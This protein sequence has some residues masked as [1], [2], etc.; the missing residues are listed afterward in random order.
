[1]VVT[2]TMGRRRDPYPAE[3]IKGRKDGQQFR[4]SSVE[5]REK[6]TEIAG[7]WLPGCKQRVRDRDRYC[8]PGHRDLGPMLDDG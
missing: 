7:V 6:K 2:Q 4:D 3:G 1:M 5:A 8:G